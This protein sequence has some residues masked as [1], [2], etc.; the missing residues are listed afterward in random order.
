MG[1]RGKT[2]GFTLIEVLV[3]LAIL[4]VALAAAARASSMSLSGSEI[5][6]QRLL[7]DWVAQNRLAEHVA[8]RDWPETG[9]RTGESEQGGIAMRW[10][11]RVSSTP[12]ASFRRIEI[13]VYA[14]AQPDH[15]IGRLS[16]FLGASAR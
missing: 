7:A 10:E 4:A 8:R 1:G 13:V 9:S 5:L 16:G 2:L 12:N 14:A 3:A 15:E 6:K 11:E